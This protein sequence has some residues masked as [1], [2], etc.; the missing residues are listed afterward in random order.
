MRT[1]DE[2]IKNK[3]W[4]NIYLL[5]GE[6]RFLVDHYRKLLIK[7]LVKEGDNMNFS[8]F[9]KGNYTPDDVVGF[10]DTMPFFADRRVALIEESGIFKKSDNILVDYLSNVLESTVLIFVE[11]DVDIRSKAY[12]A[13]EKNGTT[14]DFEVPSDGELLRW[15]EG[16]C[17]KMGFSIS[18]EA[19]H[20]FLRRMRA[21]RKTKNPKEKWDTLYLMDAES[22]KLFAYCMG[23]KTIEK[24]D[25]EE[26]C[27][28]RLE[29]KVFDLIKAIGEKNMKSAME[30]YRALIN[31]QESPAG[32]L[33]LIERQFRDLYFYISMQRVRMSKKDI[34][35]RLS[36]QGREFL[37]DRYEKQSR[38]FSE[39]TIEKM[40]SDMEDAQEACHTGRMKEETAMELILARYAKKKTID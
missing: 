30:Q 22:R 10:A 13:A 3:N 7:Y 23:K 33:I 20:E 2:D 15:M 27:T 29:W 19:N 26:I 14:A 17:N 36:L 34:A 24:K 4:K 11:T 5:Y 35:E 40:L 28:D 9:E 6:E 31:A 12:K 39:S 38:L 16:R 8:K 18:G 37:L 21:P 25:I 32:A 1:I